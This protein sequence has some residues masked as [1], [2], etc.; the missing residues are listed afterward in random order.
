MGDAACDKTGSTAGSRE[1]ALL[2]ACLRARAVD[3]GELMPSGIP[4]DV[5][6][7]IF[8]RLAIRHRM[9]PAVRHVLE[10]VA[11]SIPRPAW[12]NIRDAALGIAAA[13]ERWMAELKYLL[14][15][16]GQNNIPCMVLRGLPLSQQLYGNIHSRQISDLDILVHREDAVRAMTVL[17]GAGYEPMF[18]LNETQARAYVRFR[19]ERT[20]LRTAKHMAVDLHWRAMPRVFELTADEH[21]WS[22][23]Q[24]RDV[25]GVRMLAPDK[26]GSLLLVFAHGTKHGWDRF[27]QVLDLAM[28]L[29]DASAEEI[30]QAVDHAG[31]QGYRR[32]CLLGLGLCRELAGLGEPADLLK[33]AAETPMIRETT[34]RTR[35]WLLS[36][37]EVWGRGGQERKLLGC[38][39]ERASSK[40]RY[41]VDEVLKPTGIEV[42]KISLPR[43]LWF[44]YYVIRA[45]RLAGKAV[46]RPL[47]RRR[48]AL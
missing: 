20:Y 35:E 2:L 18:R 44:L 37:D 7:N 27:A 6:W 3:T 43:P 45:A 34:E 30:R 39:L 31:R 46:W 38:V 42:E 13:N 47:I 9:V 28:S 26:E 19:I 25:E 33:E 32:A 14:K 17:S 16:L 4:A 48:R 5:D 12:E 11:D 22:G 41:Y 8:L 1:A 40:A 36:S 24:P 29:R 23:A 10:P 15:E 21:L